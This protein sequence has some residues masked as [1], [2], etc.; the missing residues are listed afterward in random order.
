MKG[1][2]AMSYSFAV[3]DFKRL[4][5]FNVQICRF[6][7]LDNI[8]RH[9][10]SASHFAPLVYMWLCLLLWFRLPWEH[11]HISCYNSFSS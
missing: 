4:P 8:L 10:I 7:W 2:L 1:K 3:F 5:N 11:M 6:V 9:F